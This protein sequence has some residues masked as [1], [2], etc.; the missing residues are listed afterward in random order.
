MVA[1]AGAPPPRRGSARPDRRPPRE[2]RRKRRRAR[3][4]PRALPAADGAPASRRSRCLGESGAGAAP[5]PGSRCPSRNRSWKRR[6]HPSSGVERVERQRHRRSGEAMAGSSRRSAR[7]T[8]SG[9]DRRAWSEPRARAAGRRRRRD[10]APAG[11]P[12]ASRAT[13]SIQL[14]PGPLA[15]PPLDARED[16]AIAGPGHRHVEDAPALGELAAGEHLRQADRPRRG[17]RDRRSRARP[18]ERRVRVV[19]RPG[20]GRSSA[21]GSHRGRRCT[22]PA[23][24]GP[25]RRERSAAAP[26]D[27]PG[28]PPPPRLDSGVAVGQLDQPPGEAAGS[29]RPVR[30]TAR[31]A[32]GRRPDFR[33]V[34]RRGAMPRAPPGYRAHPRRPRGGPPGSA[35][36]ARH[37]AAGPP[38]EAGPPLA[39]ARQGLRK[40][41]RRRARARRAGRDPGPGGP[42]S[43][44][45]GPPQVPRDRPP[46]E[47][48]SGDRSGSPR[49]AATSRTS[50]EAKMPRPRSTRCG[51]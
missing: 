31:P 42:A 39:L 50:G 45:R 20:A 51:T 35:G 46:G 8:C 40:E 41:G 43:R 36:R 10:A 18:V 17:M 48:D 47:G 34:L 49:S 44:P 15:T 21:D 22:P 11:E 30:P 27:P 7:R 5:S 3:P 37:G 16:E 28:R 29:D 12:P 4:P 1:R 13:G 33:A 19:D 32:G 26:P 24:R 38:R 14:A 2:R 23:T 6:R 9:V 25:S